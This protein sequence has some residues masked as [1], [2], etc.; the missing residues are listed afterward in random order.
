[1]IKENGTRN[2]A[3]VLY[4]I[5]TKYNTNIKVITTTEFNK[6]CGGA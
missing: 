6:L 5:Y 4:V 3:V 1:M 2:E